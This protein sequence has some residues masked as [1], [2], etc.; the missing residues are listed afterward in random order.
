MI[1]I[2]GATGDL[3]SRKLLPGAL[4]P[5]RPAAP[6]AGDG[7]RRRRALGPDRRRVPGAAC[8][9][10][11]EK[12]SRLPVDDEIWEGFARRLLYVSVP[13]DRGRGLPAPAP[14]HR[15]R[16]TATAGTRG[17][18]LFYLATAPEFFP[19]HRREPRPGRAGRRGRRRRALRPAGRREALRAGPRVGAGAERPPRTSS[20]AS[21][22]STGSTT[23]W[24]RRRSRTCWCCGS[25]T[26]SSSRSGTAATSTTCRSPWPRTSASAPAAATT[27][28]AA[29]CATSSRTTCSRCSRS[30]PWSRPA[31]FESRDVRDEKVKVLRAIPPFDDPT[32]RPRATRCAGSTVPG[33]SGASASPATARRRASIRSPTPRRS[34]R[35]A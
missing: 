7:D 23:T 4:Q 15:A 2:F 25:A 30:S 9:T 8:A 21:G 28:R 18:R 31:R 13:F 1:V 34:W 11:V 32:D 19:G 29:R 33:G 24:G 10:G 27:T 35:C 14:S 6:A 12:H 3:T 16:R 20:S 5:G 26:P 17:N 22:R